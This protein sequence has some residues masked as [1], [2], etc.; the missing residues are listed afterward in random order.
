MVAVYHHAQKSTDQTLPQSSHVPGLYQDRP[1]EES[2]APMSEAVNQSSP[3]VAMV[4]THYGWQEVP[5]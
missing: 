1:G 4:T 5:K 2:H 3:Q